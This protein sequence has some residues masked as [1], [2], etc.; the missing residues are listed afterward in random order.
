MEEKYIEM[1]ESL[2]DDVRNNP[3]DADKCLKL[4]VAICKLN[5]IR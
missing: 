5:K 2:C 4:I 1:V 3:A